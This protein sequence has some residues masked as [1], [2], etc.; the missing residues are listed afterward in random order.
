M[1]EQTAFD[2]A[3]KSGCAR[4]RHDTMRKHSDPK[5][6]FGESAMQ[7]AR[8]IVY[9]IGLAKRDCFCMIVRSGLL[10]RACI[11]RWFAGRLEPWCRCFDDVPHH[12][13]IAGL[14]R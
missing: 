12:E 9:G 6:Q 13:V 11:L 5:S 14:S 4:S 1:P 2:A 10:P 7:K 8:E 3:A